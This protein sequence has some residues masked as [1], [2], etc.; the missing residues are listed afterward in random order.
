MN[1]QNKQVLINIIGAVESGG[2]IYGKRNYASYVAPYTNTTKEHTVTLGWPQFYG[3]YARQLIQ[4]IQQ[5]DPTTFS[6]LDTANIKR[7]LGVDWVATRWQPTLKQRE[8]L[9]SLI[10][11]PVGHE[12]QDKM[13]LEYIEPVI[14]NCETN[15]TTDP[16]AVMMYCEINHLGGKSAATRIFQKC[17]KN[18]SLNNIMNILKQD[19]TDSS[20]NNQVGDKIFWSRHEKCY[21]FINK[22][23]INENKEEKHMSV[24]VGSARIDE[25]GNIVNGLEGD[26]KQ[27]FTPDYDGEVSMQDWYLHSK[28][29][30]VIRCKDAEARDKMAYAMEAAC[31]NPHI[32][33]SQS[34]RW[35]AQDW[36][37]YKNNGNY[38]PAAI[39]ENVNTD[40]SALVRL[41]ARYAGI[42]LGDF[43]TGNMTQVFKNSGQFDIID[44]TSITNSSDNQMRGDILVT[45]SSGHTVIV[46]D[47]G[48]NIENLSKYKY[49][50]NGKAYDDEFDPEFYANKYSDLKAAFG[51]NADAL[52]QHWVEYGKQEGRIAKEVK[53]I[54]NNVD[55]TAEFDPQFY[56]DKYED[57]KNAFGYNADQ[58][59]NHWV[60]YGKNE[61]RIAKEG[62]APIQKEDPVEE[63]KVI[64]IG[65]AKSDMTVRT[66]SNSK[67]KV[68][69]YIK[70]N[71]EVKIYEQ[72]SNGWLKIEYPKSDNGFAY[73]SNRNNQYFTISDKSEFPYVVRIT[74]NALYV[75]AAATQNS[76]IKGIVH[77]NEKYSISAIE[78]EIWGKLVSGLGY[79][80]MNYAERV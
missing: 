64:A 23:A 51:N 45:R 39:T 66:A 25:N 70:R 75:R 1:D 16:K 79:I 26:Q 36:C 58:L 77:Q 47:N 80:S 34:N 37:R 63:N 27:Y 46:L 28:G 72:L 35:T 10:D 43:Y 29:W 68:L 42:I 71:T 59:L 48:K 49:V 33:Y 32:G 17:N 5:A 11:S 21:E 60:N 76:A 12:I 15:W 73:V 30:Y 19:Q 74:A 55:Y 4:R 57:L 40:C 50:Y 18:Y 56:A 65:T 52:L 54:Y 7:L 69:G 78:N 6:K 22:Y 31:N 53:Y 2:Q 8:V 61:G 44:D 20:S 67:G 13:F 62:T 3:L 38:D 9:I 24:R 41:C 14:K